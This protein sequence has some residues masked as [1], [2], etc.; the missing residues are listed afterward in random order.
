MDSRTT[1]MVDY[2]V[3]TQI[4]TDA[5]DYIWY[6]KYKS[7]WIEQGQYTRPRTGTQTTAN[8]PITMSAIVYNVNISGTSAVTYSNITTTSFIIT[9]SDGTYLSWEVRGMAV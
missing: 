1:G 8:F 3:E 2:V 5:N 4:P 9:H 6:R 7:G